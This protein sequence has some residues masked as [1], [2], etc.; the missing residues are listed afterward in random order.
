MQ[1]TAFF[2]YCLTAVI[3]SVKSKPPHVLYGLACPDESTYV[4]VRSYIDDSGKGRT[5]ESRQGQTNVGTAHP[6]TA[7]RKIVIAAF[8]SMPEAIALADEL[9]RR[10]LR[11]AVI[12]DVGPYEKSANAVVVMLSRAGS[13]DLPVTSTIKTAPPRLIPVLLED[14]PLPPGPWT[15]PAILY[16][17]NA[18][19]TAAAVMDVV[20]QGQWWRPESAKQQASQEVAPPTRPAP[21]SPASPLPFRSPPVDI[22]SPVPTT[23]SSTP[24]TST[25]PSTPAPKRKMS[26]AQTIAVGIGLL[27]AVV[28]VLYVLKVTIVYFMAALFD[29]VYGGFGFQGVLVVG[30]AILALYLAFLVYSRRGHK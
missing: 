20:A 22:P 5:V 25:R 1:G 7:L 21:T 23:R 8:T 16:Q 28:V 12:S 4:Y 2:L 18:P 29:G 10:G 24:A 9:R 6:V 19:Q 3:E 11:V 27:A 30:V 15:S 26:D 14:M 13:N 17:G